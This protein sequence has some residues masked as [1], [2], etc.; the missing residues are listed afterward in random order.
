MAGF[1]FCVPGRLVGPDRLASALGSAA[2]VFVTTDPVRPDAIAGFEI[3][4]IDQVSQKLLAISFR[5]LAKLPQYS[6]RELQV[7]HFARLVHGC[8]QMYAR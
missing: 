6:L 7:F 3:S 8:P 4:H 5:F 1:F 2:F